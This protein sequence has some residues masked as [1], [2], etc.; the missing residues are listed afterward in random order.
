MNP[1]VSVVELFY[2]TGYPDAI[3]V[4]V[5]TLLPFTRGTVNITSA[6]AF[7][8]PQINVN[9]FNVDIDL[10][11]QVASS[12]LVRQLFKTAPL[13]SLS[14]GESLPGFNVVPDPNNDG[15]SDRDWTKWVWDTVIPV[16]HPVGTC[17]MMRK[18]LGGVVDG[19]LKLYGAS[20]VRI[21]D[22][23]IMPLQISAHLSSTLY[24]IAEEAAGM[25]KNGT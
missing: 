10:D 11:I 25:I 2:D 18:D 15:G 21:V 14:T 5:W 24:A 12:K 6:D 13:S 7:V 1:L 3:G 4:D 17:A 9:Y 16:Y 23:S 22:A 20:N 8:K 19:R